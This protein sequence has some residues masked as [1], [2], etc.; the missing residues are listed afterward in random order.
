MPKPQKGY[1]GNN[2]CFSV[3]GILEAGW[4]VYKA[5][6]E[7]E[8]P[9]NSPKERL[10]ISRPAKDVPILERKCRIFWLRKMEVT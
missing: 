6:I 3:G 4:K 10:S 9:Y 7:H 2:M 1:S 5:L 8:L